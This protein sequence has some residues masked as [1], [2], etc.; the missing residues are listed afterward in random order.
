[1]FN[2]TA[3]HVACW[4]HLIEIVQLLCNQPNINPYLPTIYGIF[5][6]SILNLT[7]FYYAVNGNDYEIIDFLINEKKI[8]KKL[9]FGNS[10]IF[11]DL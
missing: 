5:F 1:M 4:G 3:L 2:E 6:N 11:I 9:L 10:Y 7:P 8:K